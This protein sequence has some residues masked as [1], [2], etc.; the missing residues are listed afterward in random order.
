[1]EII[2][3]VGLVNPDK[4]LF[5]LNAV[6][7]CFPLNTLKAGGVVLDSRRAQQAVSK[8][9]SEN[10]CRVALLTHYDVIVVASDN[11]FRTRQ[12]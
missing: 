8:Q 12:L 10:S 11:G 6:F 5:A 4:M 2:V 7:W 1:M 9:I 3:K